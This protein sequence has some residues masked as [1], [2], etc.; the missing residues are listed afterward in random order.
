[1]STRA[2]DDRATSLAQFKA[3]TDAAGDLLATARAM[4]STS[5]VRRTASTVTAVAD[6][7]ASEVELLGGMITVEG[8]RLRS[9]ATSDG[10]KG[11]TGGTVSVSGLRIADKQIRLGE[12]GLGTGD[13]QDTEIPEQP[14]P[15]AELLDTLGIRVDGVQVTRA[16]EGPTARQ[17]ATA[18]MI[19]IDTT[20]LRQ[21]LDAPFSA[22]REALPDDVASELAAL[23]EASPRIVYLIGNTAT[24]AGG[25]PAIDFAPL[26]IGE[27]PVA[28]VDGTAVRSAGLD[29][30]TGTGELGAEE[31][32]V[33]EGD[34]A[35]AEAPPPEL[36]AAPLADTRP[37]A[38]FGGV[39]GSM[40]AVGLL[41][42]G[43]IGLGV[44]KVGAAMLAGAATCELGLSGGIPSL[45][46]G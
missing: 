30:S 15:I 41:L 25:S 26:P 5:E 42:A 46:K 44:R 20:P 18:L 1:M 29:E 21:A 22:L 19:S 33:A 13:D 43:A 35:P 4:S 2:A 28:P 7:A 6:A 40:V 10:A 9:T 14:T 31:A 17:N 8:V 45:R 3:G 24:T 11:S 32:P 16:I 39:P 37:V 23:F 34:L 36:A 38:S 12:H 27:A